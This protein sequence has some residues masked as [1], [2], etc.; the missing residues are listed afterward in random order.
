MLCGD[1]VEGAED[2]C[3]HRDFGGHI[4]KG[5]VVQLVDLG[6][7]W[8]SVGC[9]ANDAEVCP[10]VLFLWAIVDD[11]FPSPP[12]SLVAAGGA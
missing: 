11:P 10:W 6:S 8:E 4:S 5:S 2:V 3:V 12:F 1:C 9:S 7:L